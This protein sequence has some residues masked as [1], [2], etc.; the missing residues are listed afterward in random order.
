MPERIT[1]RL[2][3]GCAMAVCHAAKE[4]RVINYLGITADRSFTALTK[5]ASE[6]IS[7]MGA[8]SR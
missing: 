7:A 1:I 6:A 8:G 5:S 2:H 4:R 3:G